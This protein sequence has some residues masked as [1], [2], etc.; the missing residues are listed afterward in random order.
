LDGQ[1]DGAPIVQAFGGGVRHGLRRG[2]R[3]GKRAGNGAEFGGSG[4]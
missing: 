1:I 2:L 3:R 4:V